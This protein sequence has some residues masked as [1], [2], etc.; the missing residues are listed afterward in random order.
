M[1]PILQQFKA[2]SLNHQ[3]IIQVPYFEILLLRTR[4]RFKKP[5]R[6]LEETWASGLAFC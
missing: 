4:L 5:P 6:N 1:L 2:P 3:E